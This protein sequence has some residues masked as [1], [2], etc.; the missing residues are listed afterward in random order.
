MDD[1]SDTAKLVARAA[2]NVTFKLEDDEVADGG[3]TLDWIEAQPWGR[4]ARVGAYG[5]SYLGLTAWAAL[6]A[7]RPQL[8]AI[9]PVLASSRVLACGHVGVWAM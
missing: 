1:E 5:I 2:K 9:V 4:G 6:G 8:K 3:A 7:R